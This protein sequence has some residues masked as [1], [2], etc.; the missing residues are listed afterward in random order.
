MRGHQANVASN[1]ELRSSAERIAVQRRDHRQRE[2][3][4]LIEGCIGFIG[5]LS[6]RL[7]LANR[8]DFA[9]VAARSEAPGADGRDNTKSQLLAVSVDAKC[10]ADGRKDRPTKWITLLRTVD[11]DAQHVIIQLDQNPATSHAILP[12]TR[13]LVSAVALVT[14]MSSASSIGGRRAH[15]CP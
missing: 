1:R 5:E 7:D 10:F 12:D 4:N 2:A 13:S 14:A 11:C 15:P 3:T 8:F 9:Q 6:G